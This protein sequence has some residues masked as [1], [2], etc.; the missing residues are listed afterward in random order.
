[1]RNW[2]VIYSK[3]RQETEAEAQL[4]RQGFEVWLPRLERSRRHQGRWRDVMEPLF[5]RY[6][7]AHLDLDN[8]N[9]APIRSTRGVTG[10]VRFGGYPVTVPEGVIEALRGCADPESGLHRLASRELEQGEAITVLEGPFEGLQGV[11]QMKKGADRAVVLLEILGRTS[12]VTLE[13]SILGRS[14]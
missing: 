9:V 6:L 1:M 4:R 10:F 5:P 11:F 3:P 2:Y 8:E 14:G 13:K 12:A 7:F